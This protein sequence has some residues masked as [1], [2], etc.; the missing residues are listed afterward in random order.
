MEKDKQ[1]VCPK[2][3][4]VFKRTHPEQVDRCQTC[5]YLLSSHVPL[6][7]KQKKDYP[8]VNEKS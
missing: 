6:D 4:H 2:C 8:L 5:G 3:Q 7:K 1:Q